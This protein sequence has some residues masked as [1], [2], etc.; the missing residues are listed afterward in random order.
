MSID[1]IVG[2]W[3]PNE[4]AVDIKL[5]KPSKYYTDVYNPWQTK[6]RLKIWREVEWTISSAGWTPV[7]GGFS[8][9]SLWNVSVTLW[10]KPSLVTFTSITASGWWTWAITETTQFWMDQ[11]SFTIIDSQCV[12]IRNSGWTAVHR[13]ELVS[14]NTNGFTLNC[15]LATEWATVRYIAY[16]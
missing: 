1:N 5:E 7:I 13:S 10:F 6:G 14:I 2:Y 3:I 16:P 4:W 8:I 15:I 12:Y 9:N 11:R